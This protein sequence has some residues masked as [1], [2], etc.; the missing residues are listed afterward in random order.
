MLG[1]HLVLNFV[2]TRMVKWTFCFSNGD[3]SA[4]NNDLILK[5]C[6][7][8]NDESLEEREKLAFICSC[9][10]DSVKAGGSVIIP[11]NQ[12]GI[13]LQLLEQIPVY[14]ESSAMKVIYENIFPL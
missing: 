2:I 14:L 5:E 11:L 9:V 1:I 6:L 12:L 13:V 7:L 3:C 8:R 10:V 4:D